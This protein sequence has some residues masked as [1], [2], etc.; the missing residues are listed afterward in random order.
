V[1]FRASHLFMLLSAGEGGRLGFSGRDENPSYSSI[2]YE[3][4]PTHEQVIR[5]AEAGG[6]LVAYQRHL[7]RAIGLARSRGVEVV[8]ATMPFDV[9]KFGSGVLEG[10]P[11]T[12]PV[13]ARQVE[14]NNDVVRSLARDSA[15]FLVESAALAARPDMLRDDCHFTPAGEQ[16][17]ADL[18]VAA[19]QP[20]LRRVAPV[21]PGTA[22]SR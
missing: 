10:S 8:L 2:R 9:E 21:R 13:V 20:W 14:R 4:M 18:V 19:V 22:A 7:A 17:F 11:E 3:N 16:A 5:N 15:V 6:R 1:L 12:R